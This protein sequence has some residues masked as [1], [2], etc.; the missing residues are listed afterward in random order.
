MGFAVVADE[1]RT[2]AQRSAQAAKDTAGLIE[3]AV[4][5]TQE[6]NARLADVTKAIGGV[7]AEAQH[8]RTL[9]E[10]VNA[11]SNEQKRGMGQI[12]IAIQQ[13][14]RVTQ[15]VAANAEETASAGEELAA[16][17]EQVNETVSRLAE[18]VH[19]AAAR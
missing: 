5:R 13:M 11:S 8:A 3:G 16:Q 15:Q 14:E 19:G 18:M 7:T 9:A 10:E 12:A 2:L 4:A 17:A 1:V 6:G